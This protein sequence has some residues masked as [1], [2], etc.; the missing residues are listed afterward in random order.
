MEPELTW[1]VVAGWALVFGGS[2]LTDLLVPSRRGLAAAKLLGLA[3]LGA[4]GAVVTMSRLD[5]ARA[6]FAR[7]QAQQLTVASQTYHLQFGEPPTSLKDL[8]KPP[9]GKPFVEPSA[10][11][12]PWGKPYQYDPAGPKNGGARPD[13]WTTTPGGKVIGNWMK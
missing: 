3:T 4:A 6:Q 8:V 1:G 13:V 2:L 10:L 7:A 9:E 12:D 11:T 5:D